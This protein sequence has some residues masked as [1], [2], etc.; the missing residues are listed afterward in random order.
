VAPGPL[1]VPPLAIGA[2]P[3]ARRVGPGPV[4]AAECVIFAAGCV[5]WRL[6]L[7][8]HPDYPA[9]MLP[10]TFCRRRVPQCGRPEGLLFCI[11]AIA[12]LG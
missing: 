10:G 12:G 5:F 7:T 6:S 8:L 3:L 1:L 4:A 9:D 2:G 11:D